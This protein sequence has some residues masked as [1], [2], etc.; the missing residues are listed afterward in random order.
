M[1]RTLFM[2]AGKSATGKS[3]S[4]MNLKKQEG[5]LYLNY[6]SSKPL[7]FPNKFKQI[8]GAMIANQINAIF[9]KAE[10]LPEIH[11]IVVDSITF[12]MELYESQEVVTAS[13]TRAA[14]GNYSQFFKNFMQ[15][16]VAGSTKNVILIAHN[17]TEIDKKGDEHTF[18]KVKGSLMN[19]GIEAFLSHIVYSKIIEISELEPDGIPNYD[20]ELL[21]ISEEE[22]MLGYKHV[23]Q[24]RL[25]KDTVGCRI[26]SPMGL[27]KP[28][29]TYIDNDVELLLMYLEKYYDL[30]C[31]RD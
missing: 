18:I 2:V 4:L 21:H 16:A 12:L 30:G 23:F 15:S 19:N 10:E 13:D 6:E 20:P 7:P 9:Q 3:A 22:R 27:F 26:R 24:T 28:N 25:T 8:K 17:T 31:N 29:Q 11:T 14:W 5:V 1:A